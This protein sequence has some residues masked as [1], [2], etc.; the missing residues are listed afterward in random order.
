[1]GVKFRYTKEKAATYFGALTGSS[2]GH[3][4]KKDKTPGADESHRQI[5]TFKEGDNISRGQQ[6]AARA[7]FENL[8][9]EPSATNQTDLDKSR[10]LRGKKG[11]QA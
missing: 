10:L 1:M 5:S 11:N 6:V 7:A 9:K 4:Y 8:F 3:L 2:G